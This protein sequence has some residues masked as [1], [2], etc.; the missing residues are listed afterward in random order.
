MPPQTGPT[1]RSTNCST[2][3][4]PARRT[5]AATLSNTL[6]RHEDR[7][8]SLPYMRPPGQTPTPYDTQPSHTPNRHAATTHATL[9]H[10]PTLA[11]A[12]T[13]PPRPSRATCTLCNY[14][15]VRPSPS[16]RMPGRLVH[17]R[18]PTNHTRPDLCCRS[19]TESQVP[20]APAWIPAT[21]S[22]SHASGRRCHLQMTD[23]HATLGM[24]RS[25]VPCDDS[26]A[27][28]RKD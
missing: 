9:K 7:G 5:P 23:R 10:Q 24:T 2:V 21:A 3:P 28:L 8:S 12:Q 15:S 19:H 11:T 18:A 16:R 4:H 27:A 1:N 17:G 20:A 13:S 6:D 25:V 22:P 14:S 26:R